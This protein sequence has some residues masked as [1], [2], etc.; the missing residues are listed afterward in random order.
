MQI[1]QSQTWPGSGPPHETFMAGR[2]VGTRGPPAHGETSDFTRLVVRLRHTRRL[3]GHLQVPRA[4][5]SPLRAAL[6]VP[7]LSRGLLP[8]LSRWTAPSPPPWK[9]RS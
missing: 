1:N 6:C 7:G 5:S 3:L 2:T 8:G 4:S 9:P